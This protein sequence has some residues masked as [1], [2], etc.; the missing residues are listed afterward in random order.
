MAVA[1][2]KHYLDFHG[3]LLTSL[4]PTLVGY[5]MLRWY[6]KITARSFLRVGQP[7]IMLSVKGSSTTM[8]G[9][10]RVLVL[11]S[12][13]KVMRRVVIP[14]RVI[15]S[16]VNPVKIEVMG[17]KSRLVFNLVLR[18]VALLSV[19]I[20]VPMEAVVAPTVMLLGPSPNQVTGFE[21]SFLSDMEEDLGP[22]RVE[23]SVGEPGDGLLGSFRPLP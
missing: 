17:V 8:K 22:G 14:T 3:S 13:P 9:I 18:V 10:M 1:T 6:V 20:V 12:S 2:R 7:M 5:F 16:L 15:A 11:S 19:V 23:C 21:K 4:A